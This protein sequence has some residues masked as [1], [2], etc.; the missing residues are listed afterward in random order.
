MTLRVRL[1]RTLLLAAAAAGGCGVTSAKADDPATATAAPDP[2]PSVEVELSTGHQS[3]SSPLFR[4]DPDGALV[5][6]PGDGRLSGFFR[7]AQ[8]GL[9]GSGEQGSWFFSASARADLTRV[10]GARGLDL[11]RWSGSLSAHHAL[12][13]G[14]AGIGVDADRIDVA[15]R[16]FRQSRS[17]LLDWTVARPGQGHVAWSLQLGRHRHAGDYADLDARVV[18]AS[19]HWRVERPLAG[20]DAVEAMGGIGRERNRWG[21]D[22]LDNRSGWA[23]VALEREAAGVDWSVAAMAQRARFDAGLGE[24][25]PARRD[26]GFSLEVGAAWTP[27]PG[28]TLRL[29]ALQ[30]RNRARPALYA[31]TYREIG[32]S[33][34]ARW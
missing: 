1:L 10:G 7:R 23:R 4:F 14:T 32:L 25:L 11:D 20:V 30:A 2:T 12:A 5:Y 8:L 13:G 28:S 17:L 26:R 34:A 29:S 3:S 24:L 16:A 22:D 21:Y 18:Q 15:G 33:W 6:L 9:A 19:V 31:N 27:M